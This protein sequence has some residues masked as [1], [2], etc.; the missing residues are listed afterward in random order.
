MI[1]KIVMCG[2]FVINTILYAQITPIDVSKSISKNVDEMSGEIKIMSP[3]G[4]PTGIIKYIKTDFEA[5]YLALSVYGST[6]V[7]GEKGVI[8]LLDDGTKLT[9]PDKEVNLDTDDEGFR[10][11]AFIKLSESDVKV[12]STKK[13]KKF[14]LY[15]FDK[16]LSLE[17]GNLFAN[18]VNCVASNK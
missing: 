15:I 8:V 9:W 13:I 16:N 7:V 3:I 12:L 14:R 11:H 6:C 1:G 10:Y 17:D 4:T 2:L 18:Y 5:C